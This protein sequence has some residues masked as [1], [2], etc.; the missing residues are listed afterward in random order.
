MTHF[1]LQLIADPEAFFATNGMW[2]F[3]AVG[4]IALFGIF[5][6]A[7]TWMDHRQKEREAFYKAE[8][9]RHISEAP[10]EGGNAAVQLLREQERIKTLKA[11][12]G[13]KIGGI[14][15]IGVG[16]GL[17]IFLRALIGN[18]PVFLC[19]LIPGFIGVAMILYVY[20]MARP[21][22]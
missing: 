15:N 14:I 6:P 12:E 16:L 13:L 19:G 18:Q 8:T 17:I 22:E 2:I 3:L 5:L 1:V 11:R 7:V 10:G 20:V 21:V 4:A 9:L